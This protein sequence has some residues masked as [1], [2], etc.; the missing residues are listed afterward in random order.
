M[1][2]KLEK[3]DQDDQL[4][5]WDVARLNLKVLHWMGSVVKH[6]L[7]VVDSSLST[8]NRISHVFTQPAV[9]QLTICLDKADCQ[10]SKKA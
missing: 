1:A 8:A 10:L 7:A 9:Q 3:Q 2:L 5:D 4:E 6:N